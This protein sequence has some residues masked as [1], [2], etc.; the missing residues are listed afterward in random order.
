MVSQFEPLGNE[1]WECH[2]S[3]GEQFFAC[4]KRPLDPAPELGLGR[5]HADHALDPIRDV[6][7]RFSHL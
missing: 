3:E 4:I 1:R 2:R 5:L 7:P 6:R